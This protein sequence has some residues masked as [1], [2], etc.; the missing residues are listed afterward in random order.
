MGTWK[1]THPWLKFHVDLRRAD[2]RLWLMLGECKS[3]CEHIAGVPLRRDTGE[4]LR[5]V[6]LAKGALATTAIE[7][8]TLS[9]EEAVAR[10]EGRLVLPP[11]QE[12]LGRE[13]DNIVSACNGILETVARGEPPGL[14]P[15]IVEAH[16]SSVLRGLEH[17]ADVVPGKLR[18]HRVTVGRYRAPEPKD[19]AELLRQLC[20]WLEGDTFRPPE[21]DHALVYAIVKAVVAHLY[22]AW[23]HPFGDGNGRTA[24]LVEFQVLIASGVPDPAAHLLSN[25]YNQT[26]TEY[27]RQLDKASRSGGDVMPFVEYAVRGFLDGL[28][29]QLDHIRRQ[30]WE[31]IWH[32]YVHQQFAG[33]HGETQARRRR[34]VLALSGKNE[35]VPVADLS[36]LSPA[37]AR[38]YARKTRKTLT[39]D[40]NALIEMGLVERVGPRVRARTDIILAF[41]PVRADL[42]VPGEQP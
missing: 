14:T 36:R 12:Y 2:P 18:R 4:R 34:L 24:R 5:Q 26:R 11:S 28:K 33:M 6:Y 42:R 37:T 17:D 3:K 21:P 20:D 30:Q 10:V 7:G 9:E 16:N 22:I 38:D 32:D 23:I 19:C 41:L 40:V 29:A 27:Y 1:K 13:I 25:H 15:A 31:V 39:R 35:A 8:N